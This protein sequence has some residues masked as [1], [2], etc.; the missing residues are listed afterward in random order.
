MDFGIGN[1]FIAISKRCGCI[2]L[3]KIAFLW[4]KHDRLFFSEIYGYEKFLV[5]FGYIFKFKKF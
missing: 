2:R 1:Y 4:R 3:G 5:L